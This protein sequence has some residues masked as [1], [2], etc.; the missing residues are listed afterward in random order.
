MSIYNIFGKRRWIRQIFIN[1]MPYDYYYDK[2]TCIARNDMD[3]W[4]DCKQHCSNHRIE[5]VACLLLILC[6][7]FHTSTKTKQKKTLH[8]ITDITHLTENGKIKWSLT[9]SSFPSATSPHSEEK[10][11]RFDNDI[12]QATE[13]A[14]CI[15]QFLSRFYILILQSHQNCTRVGFNSWLFLSDFV[16]NYNCCIL[17]SAFIY[18]PRP[19]GPVS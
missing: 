18:H 16:Y 1:I 7:G 10:R 12:A 17:T 3:Y 11:K 4:A 6:W 9:P 15:A 8:D 13:T 14:G 2:M 5:M 19:D